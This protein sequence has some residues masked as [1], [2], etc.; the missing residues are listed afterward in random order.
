[1]TPTESWL[2]ICATILLAFAG[3]GLGYCGWQG[4]KRLWRKLT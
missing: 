4:A 2:F 3:L 1:M